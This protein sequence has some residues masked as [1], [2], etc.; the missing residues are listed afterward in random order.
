MAKAAR[1]HVLPD[2]HALVSG[3]HRNRRPTLL[4]IDDFEPALALYKATM[5]RLGFKVLTASNGAEGVQLFLLNRVDLVITD[6]EMPELKGDAVARML[7]AINSKVPV[8][9]F[10]GSTGLARQSRRWIV[11]FCDKAGS[12]TELLNKIDQLLGRKGPD[13]LQ[14]API[15]T[16]SQSEPQRTVA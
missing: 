3:E 11:A 5:E 16:P 2:A 1:T 14:P 7:K 10:S 6:Y 13:R 15:V 4:W 12:R 8:I 9:M